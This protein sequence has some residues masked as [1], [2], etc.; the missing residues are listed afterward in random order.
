MKHLTN[1]QIEINFSQWVKRLEKYGVYSE[2]M[3]EELGDKIKK[4]PFATGEVSGGAYEGALL[5]VTL[6]HICK[7]AF[8]RNASQYGE[9]HILHCD[10]TSLMRVLLLQHICKSEMFVEQTNAWKKKNGYPY[11]FND[12]IDATLKCGAWSIAICMRYGIK[13][14]QEEVQ[15]M[16]IIDREDDKSA[17]FITPLTLATKTAN[18]EIIVELYRANKTPNTNT[19]EE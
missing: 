1:E 3:I 6:N 10:T 5:D 13:L 18:Q 16:I 17:M 11:D 14:T 15:A 7:N 4:A 2:K 19:I 12:N 8:N 9:G